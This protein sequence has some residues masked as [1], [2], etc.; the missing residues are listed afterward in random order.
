MLR[1]A[2]AGLVREIRLHFCLR[3]SLLF[4]RRLTGI[5]SACEMFFILLFVRIDS[6]LNTISV[7]SEGASGKPHSLFLGDTT[8]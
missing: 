1:V 4:R 8:T 7:S 5:G 2:F 3:N 6:M